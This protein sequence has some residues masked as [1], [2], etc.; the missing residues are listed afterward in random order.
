MQRTKA[1]L[2]K[3]IIPA[4]GAALIL[5]TIVLRDHPE[6][7]FAPKRAVTSSPDTY[8]LPMAKQY[9]SASSAPTPRSTSD[10]E[11]ARGIEEVRLRG[12]LVDYRNAVAQDNQIIQDA[13]LPVLLRDR[14]IV[15][16]YAADVLNSAPTDSDREIAQRVL[17]TLRR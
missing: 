10:E 6:V 11:C 5:V 14:E 8:P 16:R 9:P 15:L 12:T 17:E 7:G 13:L 4:I 3:V 2:F 1:A